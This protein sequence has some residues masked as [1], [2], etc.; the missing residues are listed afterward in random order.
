M[1]KLDFAVKGCEKFSAFYSSQDLLRHLAL[2]K[3]D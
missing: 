1:L 2:K 3:A